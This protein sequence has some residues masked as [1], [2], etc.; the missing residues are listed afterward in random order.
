VHVCFQRTVKGLMLRQVFD[1]TARGVDLVKI[2]RT[3]GA[4]ST[5]RRLCR[6]LRPGRQ[7]LAA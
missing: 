2:E 4:A 3:I 7:T 5:N 6:D 1:E